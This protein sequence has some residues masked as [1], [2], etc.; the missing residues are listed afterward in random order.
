MEHGEGYDL[1][2]GSAFGSFKWL[3]K[4]TLSMLDPRRRH[5]CLAQVSTARS[6]LVYPVPRS[7][8]ISTSTITKINESLETHHLGSR[9]LSR[10]RKQE[11]T[12]ASPSLNQCEIA[13]A[14]TVQ[15]VRHST[16]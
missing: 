6:Q 13:V 12:S 8:F 11:R 4:L 2:R 15:H 9:D 7:L 5:P 10:A 14:S 1:A 3:E 16:R